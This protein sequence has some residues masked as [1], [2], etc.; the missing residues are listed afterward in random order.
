MLKHGL[1]NKAAVKISSNR[2]QSLPAPGAAGISPAGGKV[3][4]CLLKKSVY[5]QLC[6]R[7]VTLAT[8]LSFKPRTRGA[9]ASLIYVHSQETNHSGSVIEQAPRELLFVSTGLKIFV[10]L[11]L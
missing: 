9:L 5:P 7:A 10:D 1:T 4:V 2:S 11:I 3:V 6:A 8:K